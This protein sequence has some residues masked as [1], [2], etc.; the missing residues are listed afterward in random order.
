MT[1]VISYLDN[2]QARSE[3]LKIILG[4]TATVEHRQMFVGKELSKKLL[5]LVIDPELQLADKTSVFQILI[6]LVQDKVFVEECVELQAA[7]KSFDFLMVNV[8]QIN[9]DK[10]SDAKIIEVQKT[11]EGGTTKYYEIDTKYSSPI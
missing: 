3:A 10:G 5:R 6:N 11:E 1:E 9:A 7:R 8:K 4:Y 2:K